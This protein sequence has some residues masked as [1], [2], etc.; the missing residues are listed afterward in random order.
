MARRGRP[1]IDLKKDIL[2]EI[3]QDKKRLIHDLRTNDVVVR[4]KLRDG[5]RS[6]QM[7][8]VAARMLLTVERGTK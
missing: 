5:N 6:W 4:K 8:F 3:A 2:D 7:A 1:L